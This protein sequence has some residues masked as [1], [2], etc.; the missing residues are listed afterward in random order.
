M[1]CPMMTGSGGHMNHSSGQ[2]DA[3]GTSSQHSH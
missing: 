2:G 3:A 1:Q